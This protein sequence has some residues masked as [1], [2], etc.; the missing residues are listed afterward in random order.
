[1]AIVQ[2]EPEAGDCFAA[3]D[4]HE[5]VLIAGPTLTECL[6]VSAGRGVD[7]EMSRLLDELGLSIVPLTAER[8]RAAGEAYR[9]WGKGFHPAALNFG[10]SFAYALAIEHECPLLFI[11]N[12]FLK[13]NV[14]PAL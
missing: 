3:I 14:V 11:G 5:N 12:D 2:D 9:R 13:T 4:A 1:M 8:A 7:R 6:I 10:D